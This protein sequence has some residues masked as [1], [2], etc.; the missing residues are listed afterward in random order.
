MRPTIE[1]FSD[2][3]CPWCYIGKR[4][5]ERA[6]AS[7]GDRPNVRVLW[8]PFELNPGMPSDG[9]DRRVYRTAKF[10]SWERS[11]ELDA[12]V[13]SV[14]A[15]A[16]IA[17][18]F[19]RIARTPNTFDAHRLIAYSQQPG[20]QDVVVERLFRAY[21]L[22][23]RNIGDQRVLAD[24]GGDAGLNRAEVEGFLASD[25]AADDVRQERSGDAVSGL[26]ESRISSSTDASLFQVP[27]SPR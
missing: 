1:V 24:V 27:R 26:T 25:Q 20:L 13:A 9:V 11:L 10:G 6:L 3:I 19:D 17:F 12:R 14:G 23:G 2:A 7:L 5:L 15:E 21:F 22:E 8:R 4:R 18:A 16:G